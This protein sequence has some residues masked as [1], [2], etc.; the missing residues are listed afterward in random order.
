MART[1]LNLQGERIMWCPSC[2]DWFR[3]PTRDP[4]DRSFDWQCPRC[5]M[6]IR[7]LRCSRCGHVWTPSGDLLPTACA[8][9]KSPYWNRMRVM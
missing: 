5:R 2:N 8:K 9:C 6:P 3:S 4:K 7:K 1:D